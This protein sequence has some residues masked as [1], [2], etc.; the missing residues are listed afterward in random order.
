MKI[1]LHAIAL[2]LAFL[3]VG[4][5]FGGGSDTLKG[6]TD[7]QPD[8]LRTDVVFPSGVAARGLVMRLLPRDLDPFA[9]PGYAAE[10][11]VTAKD[12]TFRF[13][14]ADTTVRYNVITRDEYTGLIGYAD[15]VRVRSGGRLALRIVLGLPRRVD[16]HAR[17]NP[18][19]TL[20]VR[21][22]FFAPGTDMRFWCHDRAACVA[23]VPKGVRRMLF[24]ADL[25][26]ERE[27][28]LPAYAGEDTLK[29]FFSK[30]DT[31]RVER[32]YR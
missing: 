7:T 5:I 31:L 2:S 22:R 1:R 28:E 4:C 8:S 21:G 32:G 19:D 17:A 11:A 23:V 3:L 27:L 25:G 29:L 26:W 6:G 12:G 24:R 15:S 9:L 13:P 18:S 20:F 10:V 30:E 14:M 16:A